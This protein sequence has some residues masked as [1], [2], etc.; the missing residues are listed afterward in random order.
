[1]NKKG[2]KVKKK[3][4]LEVYFGFDEKLWGLEVFLNLLGREKEVEI[5][6]R[7]FF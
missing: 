3:D 7:S 6:L 4:E 2:E 5:E 1:M